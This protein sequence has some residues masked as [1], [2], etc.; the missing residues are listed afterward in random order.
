MSVLLRCPSCRKKL[1][2]RD[3]FL[4]KK[5]KC[6]NCRHAFLAKAK[7]RNG[8]AGVKD[9]RR[10]SPDHNGRKP[11]FQPSVETPVPALIDESFDEFR[12]ARAPKRLLAA[13]GST[14]LLWF[15]IAANATFWLVAI[16]SY[17]W[18]FV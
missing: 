7:P 13:A 1:K 18:L 8:G 15:A 17:V 4:G 6:P 11:V 9:P 5:I 10:H 12:P 2:V 3:T 16:G 14:K